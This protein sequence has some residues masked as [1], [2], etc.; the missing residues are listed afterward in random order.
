MVGVFRAVGAGT[1]PGWTV[2]V[3]D[4]RLIPDPAPWWPGSSCVNWVGIDG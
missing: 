3:I 2:N 1:Q 4:P